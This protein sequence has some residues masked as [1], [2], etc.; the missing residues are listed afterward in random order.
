MRHFNGCASVAAILSWTLEGRKTGHQKP[1]LGVGEKIDDF[2]LLR[3]IGK[4]APRTGIF[5]PFAGCNKTKE[6]AARSILLRRR[7]PVVGAVR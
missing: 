2:A 5:L 6:E 4:E 1:G 7:Q 3:V